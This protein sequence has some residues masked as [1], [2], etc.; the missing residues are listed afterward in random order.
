MS[1]S[2][3]TASKGETA[4]PR[5]FLRRALGFWRGPQRGTAWFWSVAA[6]LVVLANLAVNVG[7]NRWNKWFFDALE[8]KDTDTL[9]S[10]T[11]VVLVLVVV[12]AG[13]AVLMTHCR[14]TMQV[15]WR[16]W[17]TV[18]MLQR[19]LSEQRYYRLAITDEEQ[20]NPEYRIAEDMRL[21]SE[22][23]VDFA[24]GFINALLSAVT[25][26]GILFWVGG[27]L[28]LTL[29]GWSIWIY[30][31]I[32]I[33]GVIYASLVSY[34]TYAIG[35]PLV[36]SVATRNESEAQLRYELT[37]V[38]EN[39]E[40]IALIKGAD[41]ERQ[42][43]N[44][45]FGTVVSRWLDI[46]RHQ[47]NLQWILN[48]NAFFAPLLPLFLALPKYLAGELTLGS[49]MQLAAAFTAV[50]A[51][52]NWFAENFT[53]LAEWSASARRVEELEEAI[54]D[55]DADTQRLTAITIE[56]TSENNIRLDGLSIA[57]R[58]G[59]LVIDDT[60][61][62][63]TPGERVLLG[64]ESGSGKSTLI[65]AIAGLWP[66]G[67]GR[68][69]LPTG[70]KVAFVPQRPY[71]P[72]G[73]LR[74]ALAYPAEAELLSETRAVETL[75]S[76][77]LGY[78]QAKLETEDRWDQSLSGGERQRVAFARL[79]LEEP[80]VIIMD[81]AT[82]ALDIDSELRLL[83]L[84]FE[85]L[86][87]ATI[88]SVGHRPGLQELHNRLLTLQRHSTGGRIVTTRTSG[89]QSLRN[90]G[91]SMVRF[92]RVRSSQPQEGTSKSTETREKKGD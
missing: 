6:L 20:M 70:A 18:E 27:S 2:A 39:A 42:R 37:R 68:I 47:G 83:T 59:R 23:V 1:A 71:I 89:M 22:P 76:V 7:Y 57:H 90:L 72:L 17:L 24:I 82:A 51:A 25:F 34:F 8:R 44:E 62:I 33:A 48:S 16:Q 56:N 50:L 60:D 36:N 10:A 66:W 88:F 92:L 21:A 67:E 30:G 84:L 75:K 80:D 79:L 58:D 41:D 15:K 55:M 13:F 65:R 53:R 29:L 52:L 28:Q 73:T 19:W 4:S 78:L 45:T 85:R 12:G 40:S 87:K 32:A 64:G 14:M 91:N 38:R 26:I 35:R 31:Y 63:V 81:E 54:D 74:A 86:P 43:L 69:L 46:M 9:V 77:G 5:A 61:I 3:T 49:V 11:F